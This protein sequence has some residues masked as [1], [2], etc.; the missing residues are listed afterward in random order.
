MQTG[1]IQ[2]LSPKLK[3]AQRRQLRGLAHPL[4][5]IVQ[6]GQAGVTENVV[7][8]L[9]QALFDHELVKVKVV[10]TCEQTLEEVAIALTVG[11]QSACVQQIGHI[12]LFYKANPDEPKIEL[13]K[14]KKED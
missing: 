12:L 10:N 3:G 9:E 8:Q 4:K 1:L 6:V 13:I 5:P 14:A 7:K 11:T 2:K